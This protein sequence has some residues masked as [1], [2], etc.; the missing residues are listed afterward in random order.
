MWQPCELLYTCYLLPLPLPPSTLPALP[1]PSPSPPP[2]PLPIPNS[3][4]PV[5][6]LGERYSSAT[7]GPGKTRPPN[8]FSCN[9]QPKICKPV[10][11][12]AMKHSSVRY[13]DDLIFAVTGK[14]FFFFKSVWNSGAPALGGPGTLPP[15]AHPIAT[16]LT[17]RQTSGVEV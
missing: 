12:V 6:S 7:A 14:L 13:P 17:G 15:P 1:L 11:T 9:S 16:P 4:L 2:A 3:F 5:R 10:G 8:A